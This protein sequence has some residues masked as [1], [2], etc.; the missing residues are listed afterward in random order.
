MNNNSSVF[1]NFVSG[2]QRYFPTYHGCVEM[3][4]GEVGIVM[5]F[6]G[7]RDTGKTIVLQDVFH[8]GSPVLAPKDWFSVANDLVQAVKFVHG[9]G[10]LLN[11]LKEDNVLLSR[12]GSR[13]Q[14]VVI[15]FGWVRLQTDP[16]VYAFTD[17]VK[18]QY[19]RDGLYEHVA[20]EC[21]LLDQVRSTVS[22]VFQ[23]GRLIRLIG[24]KSGDQNLF[25]IG[26][27]CCD[28]R[29]TFR[30]TIPDIE[31]ELDCFASSH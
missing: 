12:S 23:L 21:A 20:P 5:E 30:P 13:W 8:T 4:V 6:V 18:M 22:D 9:L 28:V 31:F 7:D 15:D 17:S 2:G 3:S 25:H 27:N 11:D 19:A 1:L 26:E 29:P 24:S 10:Y 14:A 16:T